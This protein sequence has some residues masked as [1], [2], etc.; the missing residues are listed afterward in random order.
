MFGHWNSLNSLYNSKYN[1]WSDN[2]LESR[3]RQENTHFEF[4]FIIK[5]EVWR[6]RVAFILKYEDN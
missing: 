5:Y 4:L 2:V 1:R 3:F 6:Y